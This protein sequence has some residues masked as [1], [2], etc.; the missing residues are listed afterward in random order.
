MTGRGKGGKGG[1]VIQ[2][3][4]KPAVSRL[5][6]SKDQQPLLPRSRRQEGRS[7]PQ[8]WRNHLLIHQ[9][10]I[11]S[12]LLSRASKNVEVH[13]CKPSR[14]TWPPPTSGLREVGSIHQE[15]LEECCCRW[16][17]H[18]NQRQGRFWIIQ[19]SSCFE[20]WGTWEEGRQT[21]GQDSCQEIGSPTKI[22]KSVAKKLTAK[23]PAAKKAPA[24]KKPAAPKKA[25]K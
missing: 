7:Q 16:K 6:K 9:S 19:I 13:H 23:K 22:K 24:A 1:A 3:I 11:W 21:K 14:N 12:L 20:K 25:K 15:V 10:A 2:G 18:P 5:S 8:R 17:A 4:T